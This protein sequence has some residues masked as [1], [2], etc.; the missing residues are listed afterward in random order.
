MV[1][2]LL[3]HYLSPYT[4]RVAV[5]LN[6]IGLPFEL[7]ELS[8]IQEP[9]RVRPH[10]PVLRLPTVVLD[11]GTS[12]IE[13]WA[14]LDEIDRIA[15]PEKALVPTLG[16]ERRRI[17]QT[18]ALAVASMEKSTA[19][20]YE[21]RFRPPEKIHQPWID[22]N[23]GQCL[24]GLQQLD[25]I[26]NAAEPSGWLAGAERISQADISTAVF[27]SFMREARPDLGLDTRFATLCRFT[28]RCE[29]LPVFR[30]APQPPSAP[31]KPGVWMPRR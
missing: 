17:M 10:N 25:A 18:M 7:V 28:D 27:V 30:L 1:M 6:V 5:S 11:D 2:K 21:M 29:Q 22:H 19:V 20:S 26:A 15:G 12:L 16:I 9:E 23:N 14:I 3:G 24:G 4:R 8:V 31:G 13:S